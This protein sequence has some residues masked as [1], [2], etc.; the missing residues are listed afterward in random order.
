RRRIGS[1]AVTKHS[2]RGSTPSLALPSP[3][4]PGA[5]Q[6]GFA[7]RSKILVATYGSRTARRCLGQFPLLPAVLVG[8]GLHASGHRPNSRTSTE[9][10]GP[11]GP[12]TRATT[13]DQVGAPA[14]RH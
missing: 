2:A 11:R 12:N 3:N 5:K 4:S 10:L 7:A 13:G 1:R 14:I 9:R 8:S 6:S